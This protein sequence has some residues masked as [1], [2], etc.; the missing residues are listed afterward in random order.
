MGQGL[1]DEALK[2]VLKDFGLTEIEAEI[3]L[4]LAR[5]GASKGTEV[6]K[7]TKKDKAQ[8][9]HI[10]RNLQ[11]KGLVEST[12]EA[13]VR[14]TPVSF[15]NVV[16][17]AIKAKKDEATEIENAKQEL[18]EYWRNI[19]RYKTEMPSEKFTVI[20]GRHKIHLKIARMIAQTKNQ[21]STIT[22]INELLRAERLGIYNGVSKHPAKQ[23]IQF[24]FLTEISSQSI[25][26][27]KAILRKAANRGFDFRGRTPELGLRLSPQMIIK[28]QEEAIF[29]IRPRLDETLPEEDVCL[30]TNCKSL[31][32]AFTTV[33]EDLWQNSTDIKQRIVEIE[34]GK[35]SAQTYVIREAEKAQKKYMEALESAKKDIIMITSPKTLMDPRNLRTWNK[36]GVLTRIMAPITRENFE[37]AQNIAKNSEI[38][39]IHRSYLA[40]TIIDD[41]YLFQF[42]DAQDRDKIDAVPLF[43][44]TFFSDDAEYVE[45]TKAM[46]EDVWKNSQKLSAFNLLSIP[47]LPNEDAPTDDNS[48][49]R[50][51][52]KMANLSVVRDEESSKRLTE[53]GILSK[54][55]STQTLSQ[56]LTDNNIERTYGTNAQIIIHPPRSLNLPE[57][58]I[59]AYHMEKQSTYGAEDALL[60]HLWLNTPNGFAFVH[61]TVVTDNPKA[62][63]FWKRV[64]ACSPAGHNVQ[65]IREN[66]LETRI[67]GNTFFAG[68][69]VPIELLEQRLPP[70]CLLVEGYGDIKTDAYVAMLPSGYALKTAGN[71][72]EAFVTFLLPYSKYSGPGTDGALGRDVIMEFY[73]PQTRKNGENNKII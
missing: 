53:E 25:K 72:L 70:A 51:V 49:M 54:F 50:V 17:S 57:M 60:I 55:I 33:F 52:K 12:L 44:D 32:Q 62:V 36:T 58:L 73:P 11:S 22:T 16:E 47:R 64:S 40:T 30:W 4:F 56:R 5:Q 29:F 15:E 59:H 68:W 19:S 61:T 65:L 38:R 1:S 43:E 66:E 3:Y 13:P 42:R 71:V 69:T 63:D 41:K 9:Y 18:L 14:F 28:D 46:L 31:V 20:E 2:R 10:L 7:Q 6:A 21:L 48:L 45:K 24:R 23:K 37:A 34:S 26:P 35:P 8:I 39:H 27:M 67:H